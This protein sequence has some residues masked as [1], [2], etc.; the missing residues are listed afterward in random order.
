MD[1]SIK[2]DLSADLHIALM[3]SLSFRTGSGSTRSET[4]KVEPIL[5]DSLASPLALERKRMVN[6]VVALAK[7]ENTSIVQMLLR[8]YDSEVQR[9]REG[10]GQ[11]IMEISKQNEGR[12]AII[13]ALSNPDRDVRK[14]AKLIIPEIWGSPSTPYP[15]L[16]EQTFQLIQMAKEKDIPVED[17]ET[18]MEL[19]KQSF[20]DMEVM[21]SIRDIGTCLE[22]SK[23]RY[24]NS[25]SLK[26]YISDMLKLSPELQRMGVT[27]VNFDESL[28]TAI[29]ASKTR[30]FDYTQEIIDQRVM[31]IEIKD[32]LRSL[33][34]LVKES[35]GTRPVI[36]IAILS[37]KDEK[38]I[39][40]MSQTLENINT[41]NLGGNYA[42]S[43]EEMHEFL[44]KDFEWYY[45]EDVIGRLAEG[46]R[47]VVLTIYMIGICLL[48]LAS[49]MMPNVAE[50]IYQ[51][52]YR[53]LEGS[54]S[55]YMILW[56]E[57]V[58][59]LARGIVRKGP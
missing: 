37:I 56:P 24:K 1:N 53:D 3:A 7:K 54:T 25:E 32:Q 27:I 59:E 35:I 46:D 29:K 21:K 41:K 12:V 5:I 49:V 20:L 17:I 26:G 47:S 36:E 50:E 19:S 15:T 38:M 58:I 10:I 51:K 48:K 23:R 22:F 40:R 52:Y 34:Q 44:L 55:V 42:K 30:N 14:G 39:V 9:V 11:S 45:D 16:F 6:R 57:L 28:R 31:E 13:E 2:N 4:A 43:V 33:G 18:L 8:H